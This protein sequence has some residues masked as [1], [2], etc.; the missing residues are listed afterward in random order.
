MNL[1]LDLKS[2]YKKFK[3]L[4]SF[5]FKKITNNPKDSRIYRTK[6]IYFNKTNSF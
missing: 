3:A 5:K 2:K 4:Q 6:E 1:S